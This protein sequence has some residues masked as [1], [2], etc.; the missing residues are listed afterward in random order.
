MAQVVIRNSKTGEEYEIAYA[1]FRRGHHYAK[2]D[3][4]RVS[5]EAAGFRV[6]SY[7]DG[8]EYS[9]PV[10][11]HAPAGKADSDE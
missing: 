4:E 8:S 7:A 5:F 10:E 9:A 2:P 11:R 1:D 6:V 3:G